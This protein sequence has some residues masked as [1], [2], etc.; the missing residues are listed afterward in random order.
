MT[1]HRLRLRR[2]HTIGLRR[3]AKAK[4]SGAHAGRW[5]GAIDLRDAYRCRHPCGEPRHADVVEHRFYDMRLLPLTRQTVYRI[6]YDL[7]VVKRRWWPGR[8]EHAST[9]GQPRN[10]SNTKGSPF[11]RRPSR[12]VCCDDFKNGPPAYRS[13]SRWTTDWRSQ[14]STIDEHPVGTVT[15]HARGRRP[16]ALGDVQLCIRYSMP[17]QTTISIA[18]REHAWSFV[19]GSS[20]S[21]VSISASPNCWKS[22]ALRPNLLC[23]LINCV[24]VVGSACSRA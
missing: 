24:S 10:L 21:K 2:L 8:Y 5:A 13:H 11:S 16:W 12:L 6:K 18:V 15:P 19:T 17:G 22:S 9:S 7:R 20:P 1:Q 3:V 14:R 4:P 23:T